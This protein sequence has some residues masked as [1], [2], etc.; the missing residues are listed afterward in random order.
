MATVAAQQ[1]NSILFKAS[2]KRVARQPSNNRN[3]PKL[4][5]KACRPGKHGRALVKS[6]CSQSGQVDASVTP[7]YELLWPSVGVSCSPGT[8]S[9][10]LFCAWTLSFQWPQ[11]PY[12]NAW[13]QGRFLKLC[14]CPEVLAHPQEVLGGLR[15][16]LS[17]GTC[18]YDL[19]KVP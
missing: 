2:G 17:M 6:P 13:F 1:R 14:T 10:S 18:T 9:P 7:A 15:R 16:K 3:Y 11:P 5:I 8:L 12:S 4:K 19:A